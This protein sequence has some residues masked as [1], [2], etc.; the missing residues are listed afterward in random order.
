MR[1]DENPYDMQSDMEKKSQ[2]RTSLLLSL[3]VC[4]SHRIHLFVICTTPPLFVCH[5][6]GRNDSTKPMSLCC[7]VRDQRVHEIWSSSCTSPSFI[8]QSTIQE[9]TTR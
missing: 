6:D 5:D 3:L 1:H 2:P 9:N 4:L 7:V 8:V